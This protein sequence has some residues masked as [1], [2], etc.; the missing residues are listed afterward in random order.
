MLEQNIGCLYGFK[1]PVSIQVLGPLELIE[2]V[3]FLN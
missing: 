3:D 2:L 1:I